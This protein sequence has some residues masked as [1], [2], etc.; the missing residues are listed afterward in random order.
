MKKESTNSLKHYYQIVRLNLN[1]KDEFLDTLKIGTE[2][3]VQYPTNEEFPLREGLT[4]Q[5]YVSDASGPQSYK[6][7]DIENLVCLHY[8]G[9]DYKGKCFDNKSTNKK[10]TYL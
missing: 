6:F 1:L 8:E 10:I 4:Y 5:T 9:R 3:A 2:F 7:I